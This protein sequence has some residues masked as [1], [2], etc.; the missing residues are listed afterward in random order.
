MKNVEAL[1]YSGAQSL[2]MKLRVATIPRFLEKILTVATIPRKKN[3][4]KIIQI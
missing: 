4:L 2:D 1:R 3:E